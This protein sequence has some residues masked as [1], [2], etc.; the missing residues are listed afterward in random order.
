MRNLPTP[1]LSPL[2]RV[3]CAAMAAVALSLGATAS[4]AAEP[5]VKVRLGTVAWIGYAPFY[6]AV[7][8]NLF[9]RYGLK[10][11]LQDFP[12]PATMP[13]AVRSGGLQGG[14]YTY[15][16]IITAV[17]QAQKL[18]VVLPIDY[19]NGAD[20]IVAEKSLASIADLKGRKVAYPFS[21][22]DNLLVVF[23]L[24]KAG[25]KESDILG[26]DT[27][28]E[29][30]AAALAAGAVAGATYEPNITQILK[31]G[32]G[33]K[34]KVLLD[35]SAAPGL[36]TDVLFFDEGFI[37]RNPK[38]VEG[39]MRGYL[40]GLALLRNKPEEA[41]KIVAKY[42]GVTPEEV[43]QQQKGVYNIPA[44]EMMGYFQKRDDS[45]SLHKVGAGIGD[46]L[47]HRGQIKATPRIEDT[48]DPRFVE[49]LAKA[50]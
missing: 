3:V 44:A 12:D 6:V 40:D 45:K 17:A 28:P 20:A 46:I 2:R 35:S 5:L 27:T 34:Y 30:V 23:A 26:I 13:A 10:V 18:R 31:L 1:A 49:A 32:G 39:V 21:T 48:F 47:V 15:D 22:C 9:A 19:S 4:L 7:A 37:A 41:R 43:K 14:M 50:P 38:A 29:N 36:I 33:G 8:K 11:E 42:I 24:E 16:L 25:L